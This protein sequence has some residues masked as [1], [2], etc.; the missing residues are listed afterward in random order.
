MNL[1]AGSFDYTS[2]PI[3]NGGEAMVSSRRSGATLA[4]AAA[5]GLAALAAAPVEA[6]NSPFPALSG[7]WTGNGTITLASGTRERIRCM[8]KYDV[9]GSGDNLDLRLRC[10]G[11]SFKFELQSNVAHTGGAVTGNWAELTRRVGGT[12]D[13][14]A[15][16]NRIEVRVQGTI[17]AL[18]AV[19]TNVNQQQIS[20]E[21]PSSDMSMV[22]ISLSRGAK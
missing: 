8:A 17:S 18:L 16:G 20:I 21:A 2:N 15:K 19:N 12:I 14:N 9:K 1:F 3:R 7:S 6:A 11:D 13:G 4:F 22:A 10:A 5:A